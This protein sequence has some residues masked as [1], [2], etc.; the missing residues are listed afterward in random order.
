VG[1]AEIGG[2]T[3]AALA[4]I[5]VGDRL[6]LFAKG[7]VDKRIY[8]KET[9]DGASWSGW[10]EVRGGGTTD[11][12]LGVETV[13]WAVND[14]SVYLFSKGIADKRIYVNLRRSVIYRL[15]F[16]DVPPLPGLPKD[17]NLTNGNWDDPVHGHGSLQ[18][19]AFDFAA[20]VG[21]EVRAA[22]GGVVIG[23]A[24]DRS[25]NTW[26]LKPGDKDY[27]APGEGNFVMI[28][29]WDNTVAAYDHLQQGQVFVAQGDSVLRG[30][31]IAHSGN[32]G[33]SSRPHLHF[34]VRCYWNRPDD[35]GPTLPVYFEDKQHAC[36][37][38]RVGDALASNND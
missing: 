38:P 22:R 13:N 30:Q 23:R 8:C 33:N 20:S 32:T 35:V 11:A 18:A 34:D 14:Q 12:G 5:R 28:R 4:P 15:P 7:I 6:L 29:H 27:G 37:R 25:V 17:W 9:T 21:H 10:T 1:W 19:Y 26:G 2:T 24:S 36:W 31:V 16:A 3:D